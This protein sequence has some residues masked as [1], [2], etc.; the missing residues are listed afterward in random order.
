[1]QEVMVH[2]SER[3]KIMAGLPPCPGTAKCKL[4]GDAG[5]VLQS[6]P[7]THKCADVM[8]AVSCFATFRQV[9]G[10]QTVDSSAPSLGA[11]SW[12]WAKQ[13]RLISLLHNRHCRHGVGC[14]NLWI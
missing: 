9:H 10:V 2:Q 12:D 6:T 7:L 11:A 13:L 1:M 5:S 8:F 4:V 3:P 14:C